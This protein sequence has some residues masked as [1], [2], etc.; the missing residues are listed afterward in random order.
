MRARQAVEV[1][2]L[3]HEVGQQ[4]VRARGQEGEVPADGGGGG[5][6]EG[7]GWGS[8]PGAGGGLHGRRRQGALHHGGRCVCLGEDG[9]RESVAWWPCAWMRRLV[10]VGV[11]RA[12]IH[13]K[14][15]QRVNLPKLAIRAPHPQHDL[16]D[17][18]PRGPPPR[19]VM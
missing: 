2:A 16:G 17:F 14:P 13:R 8:R 11:G 18:L 9:K 12:C 4:Q 5:I 19:T 1:L 7:W 15:I 3:S 6:G 10:V